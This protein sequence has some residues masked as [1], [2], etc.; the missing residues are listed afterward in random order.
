MFQKPLKAGSSLSGAFAADFGP[1]RLSNIIRKTTQ[2]DISSVPFF[3]SLTIPRLGVT[4]S[5]DY[6]TSSLLPNVFCKEGLLQN[7]AVTIPK[8][9]QVFTILSL[10]GTEVPLKMYYYKSFLSFEVIQN[11]RL[12]IGTLLSTIP[13]INIRSLPLPTG[14]K[15]IFQF[16][17]DYFSLDTSSKQLVVT[18]QYPGTLSYFKDYLTITNPSLSVYAIL[19]H[20]RK[21]DFAVNGAIRIGNGFYNT[22]ISRDPLTNKY[23]VKAYFGTIPISDLI[24]KFSAAILP[25]EFQK[26]LK[27]FIQFSIHNAK[28]ALPLGTRNLQLHLSGTPVIGGYKTVHLSVIIARQGEKK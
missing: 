13:G 20:P 5:S 21:T 6:I 22:T 24:R 1:I 4:V 17:I 3:G 7:T 18:T 2:V 25:Q 14:L 27:N 11:G 10:S 23:I 16:Q 15:E 9:L 8:G 12:P 28:L 19:K 26:R